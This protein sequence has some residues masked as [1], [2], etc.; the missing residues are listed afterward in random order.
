MSYILII[1][2]EYLK[3]IFLEVINEI[4]SKLNY[5]IEFKI[6]EYHDF[7]EIPAIYDRHQENL[8]GI[9]FSGNYVMRYALLNRHIR[10]PYISVSQDL[11]KFYANLLSI[12]ANYS[13]ND[14]GTIY[15]DYL[16]PFVNK[17]T[18]KYFIENAQYEN[19]SQNLNQISKN[20]K[21][22][23]LE[24]IE[25]TI[26]NYI[27]E[28]K[29]QNK[30]SRVLCSLSSMVPF[31]L[32]EGI[33][34]DVTS[35][36]F[37]SIE[38]DL[39]D[40]C[41]NIYGKSFDIQRQVVGVM[42]ADSEDEVRRINALSKEFFKSNSIEAFTY[43]DDDAVYFM[44]SQAA[45]KILTNN[46]KSNYLQKFLLENG[47][48]EVWCGFGE[49]HLMAE[50]YRFARQALEESICNNVDN[51][52]MLPDAEIIYLK[53]DST[54]V[55]DNLYSSGYKGIINE[56]A[57]KS[58]LSNFTI[59]KVYNLL[60]Q[61]NDNLMT[62]KDLSSALE[63]TTRNAN[64]ILKNLSEAGYAQVVTTSPL[65]KRGRPSRVYRIDFPLNS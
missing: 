46:Y 55:Q 17:P 52:I 2:S 30:V 56:I 36:S 43:L 50:A 42:K 39:I 24:T 10:V 23:D 37:E 35:P 53:S 6:E 21:N 63:V 60:L 62:S 19:I 44:T 41:Q 20:I 48:S 28:M 33:E 27:L 12:V 65:S 26:K 9:V 13:K 32:E 45:I 15:I 7:S 22:K 4:D 18:L 64:R 59:N 1:T 38:K 47:I 49:S 5:G 34:V 40:F 25:T 31:Y 8:S 51:V 57:N 29:E 54:S 14:L 16:I 3:P 58:N 11:I 61:S